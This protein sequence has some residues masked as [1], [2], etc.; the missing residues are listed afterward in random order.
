[1]SNASTA[2]K[3][4]KN[5]LQSYSRFPAAIVKGRGS[6]A[7]DADGKRYLDFLTGITVNMLGH[8][9]P[10]ITGAM[11][12]Q[13]GKITH[14]GNL[15][16]SPLQ[17]EMAEILCKESFASKVAF[18]NTGAE[19][20]ELCI[21]LAR[22]WGFPKGRHEIIT[23]EGSFHGRTYGA[24]TATA[25]KK[26][27]LGLGPMLPGFR[28]AKYN[29][30]KSAEKLVG[31]KTCA[32]MVEP[33]QGEGGINIGEPDFLI[34]LRKLCDKKGLLLIVDEIQTGLG[35]TG[36]LFCF[37]HFGRRFVPDVM[38][39]GKALGGG[40]PLSAVLIGR[41][42]E[43]LIGKGEHGT[44]MGGNAVAVAGGLA[45]LKE[46]KAG[47][48]ALRAESLGRRLRFELRAM[49]AECPVIASVRGRGLM[50]G[51]QLNAPSG[52]AAA[53]AFK[54][55]LI[56]NATAGNVVRLHPPLNVKESE[57]K[58]ALGI[59]KGVFK[60]MSKGNSWH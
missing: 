16:Y 8:A 28:Y 25:Q 22:K 26:M 56:V 37:E 14:V 18:L 15:F 21:K 29:D 38:S 47:K 60:E 34:G 51:I 40:L 39:L 1:V 35:R 43:K 24:L 53:A 20:N 54:K 17:A 4:A 46:L 50:I 12:A 10:R 7:F 57:L 13:L 9:H 48:Y 23:F 55:G 19:A 32:I 5:I 27:H 36:K 2:S 31:K 45:L 59:L 44:T 58:L 41:K 52:P 6:W 11:K 30:L 42:A 3:D 33:V 49:K